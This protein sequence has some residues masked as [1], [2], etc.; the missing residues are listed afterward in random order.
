MIYIESFIENLKPLCVWT[1][2]IPIELVN[3][4]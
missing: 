2:S 1:D 4:Q 3:D